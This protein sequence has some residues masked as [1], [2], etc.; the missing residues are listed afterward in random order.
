M[1]LDRFLFL[2]SFQLR[3]S[4]FEPATGCASCFF[5][6]RAG[7]PAWRSIYSPRLPGVS[8]GRPQWPDAVFVPLHGCGPAPDFHRTSH[9]P[10]GAKEQCEPGCSPN[11]AAG[12]AGGEKGV[13]IRD[14]RKSRLQSASCLKQHL[15]LLRKLQYERRC[16][17]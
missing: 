12:Q 16:F 2:L 6:P 15:T 9:G 14:Q 4:S 3:A 11:R 8:C 5:L 7:L 10:G 1:I 17:L 13:R